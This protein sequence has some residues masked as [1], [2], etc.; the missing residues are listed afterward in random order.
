MP[1]GDL[2]AKPDFYKAHGFIGEIKSVDGGGTVN[3][4]MLPIVSTVKTQI[5]PAAANEV[6]TIPHD[7][8]RKCEFFGRVK[9]VNSSVWQML[10]QYTNTDTLSTESGLFITAIT[11]ADVKLTAIGQFYTQSPYDIEL[12]FIDFD[13]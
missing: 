11:N 7:A 2:N 12:Y 13:I 1:P 4:S 3:G 6:I 10:P 8:G 9:A 5:A